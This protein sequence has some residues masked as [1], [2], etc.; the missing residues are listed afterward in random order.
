MPPC[1]DTR[2]CLKLHSGPTQRTQVGYSGAVILLYTLSQS[3]YPFMSIHLV[4]GGFVALRPPYNRHALCEH[5]PHVAHTAGIA[6][7]APFLPPPGVRSLSGQV[8]SL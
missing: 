1:V 3:T 7:W 4:C 6:F 5:I 8:V 2:P